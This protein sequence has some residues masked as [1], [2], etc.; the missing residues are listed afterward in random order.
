MKKFIQICQ[1][2]NDMQVKKVP[3]SSQEICPICGIYSADG[4]VCINC[5]KTYGVYKPKQ[6]YS[7]S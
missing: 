7:D 3:Y 1:N 4:N 5:Q 6:S 2:D